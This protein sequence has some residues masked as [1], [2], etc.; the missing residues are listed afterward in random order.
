MIGVHSSVI[1]GVGDCIYGVHGRAQANIGGGILA[2]TVI[3]V[4]SYSSNSL[5]NSRYNIDCSTQKINTS[6]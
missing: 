2:K 6:K 4:I 1:R 3:I 5:K